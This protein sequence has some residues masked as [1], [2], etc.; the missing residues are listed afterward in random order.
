MPRYK[1]EK[2]ENREVVLDGSTF[3]G[4]TFTK[5]R[6]VFEGGAL[7]EMVNNGFHDCE[8]YFGG[9]AGRTMAFLSALYAGG[10]DDVAERAFQ[11]IRDGGPKT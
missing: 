6:V 2:F 3:E 9:P 4:C 11:S 5:C 8:W 7:P 10:L 1:D